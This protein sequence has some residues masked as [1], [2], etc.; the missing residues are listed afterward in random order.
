MSG[1]ERG[2]DW[3][4]PPDTFPTPAA[5]RP[6]GPTTIDVAGCGA[7]AQA[8]D[9]YCTACGRHL[10]RHISMAGTHAALPDDESGT[11]LLRR[12][13]HLLVTGNITEAIPPLEQ[14][15]AAHPDW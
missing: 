11:S 2:S 13:H 6:S 7:G 9:Q 5:V 8:D 10:R 15:N 4:P 1:Y 12:A 14:L 3:E